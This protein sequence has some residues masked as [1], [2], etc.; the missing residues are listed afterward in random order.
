MPG[1]KDPHP[2]P[3]PLKAYDETI[4]VLKSVVPE[5]KTGPVGRARRPLKRLDEESR[6]LERFAKGPNIEA[7]IIE[8]RARSHAYSGRSVFGWEP[9]SNQAKKDH[10]LKR[11]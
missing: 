1:G 11:G 2:F 6:R 5:S 10:T 4:G 3:V 7:L 8:E 9:A